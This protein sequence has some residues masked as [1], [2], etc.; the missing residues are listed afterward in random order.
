[1]TTEK[2]LADE[3]DAVDFVTSC[4][5]GTGFLMGVTSL[6]HTPQREN[7]SVGQFYRDWLQC[8]SP[9]Q[10]RL[11]VEPG[12]FVG[13]LNCGLILTKELWFDLI[14]DTPVSE[15]PEDW[16]FADLTVSDSKQSEPTLRHVMRR[17]R[18]AL[19]HGNIKL[20]VCGLAITDSLFHFHDE[21]QRK[22]TFD[23]VISIS[24]LIKMIRK[25]QSVV[26][27][28]VRAKISAI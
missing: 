26:H 9:Q 16:G 28:H 6:L 23:A 5:M 21:S 19:A 3:A 11:P 1:M 25:F 17:I 13:C 15:A 24:T 14:L 27:F 4:I 2:S 18:N 8:A 7:I 12:N 22:G 10:R 20:N